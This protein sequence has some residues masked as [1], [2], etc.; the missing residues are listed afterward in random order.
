MGLEKDDEP[1]KEEPIF[2]GNAISI[3]F[4]DMEDQEGHA[5]RFE[6]VTFPDWVHSIYI[7]DKIHKVLGRD[8]EIGMPFMISGNYV[9]ITDINKEYLFHGLMRPRHKVGNFC[10]PSEITR[11]K[12]KRL[13]FEDGTQG[14]ELIP[15]DDVKKE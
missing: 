2:S 3:R 6:T 7:N 15:I 14:W 8:L 11:M 5:V 9:P 13:L 12:Y 1:T 10:D 4:P